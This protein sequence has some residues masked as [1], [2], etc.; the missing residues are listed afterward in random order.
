MPEL[1]D[2]EVFSKNLTRKLVGKK[3]SKLTISKKAK[4]KSSSKSFKKTLEGQTLK[5][6]Y[7]EGKELY[8]EFSKGDILALHLMLRGE[9]FVY[10]EKHDRKSPIIQLDFSDK[11]GFVMTDYQWAAHP[12][13][14]P[15]E[16]SA[17]DALSKTV[18]S[19]FLKEIIQGSKAAVKNI[20][21]DQKVIRGIG[22]AY[23]DEI[24]W[25]AKI[26][27]ASSGAKIPDKSINS[28]SKAIKSVLKN[29][30]KQ[31]LKADP[32]II[33]GEI[34]DFLV[35]HNHKKEKSPTG[36]KI[37]VQSGS[38]KTYYTD[39]QELFK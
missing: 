36:A 15:D 8:F 27:P 31:I 20:L 32:E 6:I 37:K 33:S 13:L 3:L 10:K 24:L 26:S 30:Q 4:I 19:K 9:M 25:K 21:L 39:E 16:K 35:I 11:T 29:A 18:T 22:N 38:R 5:K 14:N 28:L 23:A 12:T 17:P 2:L 7:R 34:R 1:P